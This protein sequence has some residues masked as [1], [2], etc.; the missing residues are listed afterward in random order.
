MTTTNTPAKAIDIRS[1]SFSQKKQMQ[2][3]KLLALVKDPSSAPSP[4]ITAGIINSRNEG[5]FT[6]RL[7]DF[8]VRFGLLE[9]DG[10]GSSGKD[11]AAIAEYCTIT[12]NPAQDRMMLI[13]NFTAAK[14]M[15]E[16]TAT[17][18]NRRLNDPQNRPVIPEKNYTDLATLPAC[19]LKLI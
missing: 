8:C 16:G 17:R 6:Y 9:D 12:S 2:A 1:Y 18:F 13:V 7:Q 4:A 3:L 19:A 10:T 15:C 14:S 5:G 11:A